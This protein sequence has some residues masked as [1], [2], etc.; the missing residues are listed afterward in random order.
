MVLDL[1]PASPSFRRW[2][3]ITLTPDSGEM[4]YIPE[5][6]AHGYLTLADNTDLM[7]F[8]SKPYVAH[9]A[10]G[11]RYDDRAF[12]IRW[13]DAVRVVSS[14]DQSWPDFNLSQERLS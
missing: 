10:S 9:A 3:G 8:T 7:Y 2:F 12:D 6:C 11:V 1:R 13:P 5:G 4:L 14:A